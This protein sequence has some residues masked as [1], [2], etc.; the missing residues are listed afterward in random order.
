[1]SGNSPGWPT[2]HQRGAASAFHALQPV[3]G[4]AAW[5]LDVDRPALVL[6]SAQDEA[7]ADA[8]R[9]AA[10]GVEIVR[11]RSGG[12]AVVLV[13]GRC[14]WL[15][16]IV[17][18]DDVLW[19]DDIGRSMWWFGQMWAEALEA[20]GCSDV[21]VHRGPIRHTDWSR[22]VC[23]DGLGAGEVTVGGRKAVGISQRRTR[24]WAR[25]QSS[26]Y[27]GDG[28]V[29]MS[30]VLVD[31]LAPPHPDADQLR[32]PAVVD[33]PVALLQSAVDAVLTAH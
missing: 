28:A 32:P 18:R 13:P 20:L 14:T 33:V 17:P 25:L 16:V 22:L 26:V 12:G 30:Q 15:D 19:D 10:A 6:G 23:F 3:G 27:V 8:A 31:L 7:V 24:D 5:W 11:R 9:C 4:R 1:V 29:D 21:A 2:V